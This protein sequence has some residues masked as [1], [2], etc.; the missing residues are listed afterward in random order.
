MDKVVNNLDLI[1][2][3]YSFGYPE[4]RFYM[5]MIIFHIKNKKNKMIHNIDCI[6]RDWEFYESS[7]YYG[8]IYDLFLHKLLN[9]QTQ[10]KLIKQLGKCCCC[11][12]HCQNKPKVVDNEIVYHYDN[13]HYD[14]DKECNCN[15]RILSRDLYHIHS[16]QHPFHDL[17]DSIYYISPSELEF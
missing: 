5:K 4:H 10:F 1:R 16:F 2:Y 8:A 17:S 11:N 12:R 6:L 13:K 15:C 9:K 3:I 7:L 14:I